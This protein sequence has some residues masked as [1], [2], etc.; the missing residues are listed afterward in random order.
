MAKRE[1]VISL[2]SSRGDGGGSS[3]GIINDVTL[4][5]NQQF[6]GVFVSFVSYSQ[7]MQTQ[8]QV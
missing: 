4:R 7:D 2:F 1:L 8:K 3:S 6:P 5:Q